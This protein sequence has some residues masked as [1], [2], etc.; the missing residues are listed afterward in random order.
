MYKCTFIPATANTFSIHIVGK[1]TKNSYLYIFVNY[2]IHLVVYE[3]SVNY[4]YVHICVYVCILDKMHT[5]FCAW[6][7]RA[8]SSH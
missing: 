4:M 3:Y 6:M 5:F 8:I 7:D 1:T 2:W